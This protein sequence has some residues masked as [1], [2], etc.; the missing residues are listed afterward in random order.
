MEIKLFSKS[1]INK[2]SQ[3]NSLK[4]VRK[5]SIY[6]YNQAYYKGVIG[7]ADGVDHGHYNF[8]TDLSQN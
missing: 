7:M 8:L 4:G 6:A 3:Q 1:I 5:K 2:Y